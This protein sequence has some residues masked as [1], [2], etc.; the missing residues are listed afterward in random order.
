MK[1]AVVLA[2]ALLAAGC[3]GGNN[4]APTTTA[5][6]TAS[7]GEALFVR[8]CGS[9]HALDAANTTAT[10]GGDLDEVKPGSAEVLTAI[11]DG[12]GTM[13]PDILAG[14]DA[15]VVADYVAS[16]AGS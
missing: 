3:G 13:P 14:N 1:R 12:P 2:A 4:A 6:G 11:E 7:P 8:S 16:V 9:C 10:F 15:E 5:D